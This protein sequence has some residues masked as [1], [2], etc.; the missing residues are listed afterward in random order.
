[1][2]LTIEK[3][4]ESF[5]D[6]QF[7]IRH[8]ESEKGKKLNG[9]LVKVVGWDEDLVKG[10]LHCKLNSGKLLKLKR[11]CVIEAN[12]GSKV[13]PRKE[14]ALPGFIM[15]K[16]FKSL[17]HFCCTS[18]A[19]IRIQTPERTDVAQRLNFIKEQAEREKNE[20]EITYFRVFFLYQ[21][22]QYF[23]SKIK[24]TRF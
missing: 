7:E 10:R 23:A 14:E 15:A 17:L 9:C 11:S 2:D 1:M 18:D 6:R 19:M 16:I 12:I 8:L 5:K 13:S 4:L 20:S 24:I 3:Y 22:F 21:A